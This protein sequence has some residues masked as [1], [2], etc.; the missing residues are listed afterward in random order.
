MKAI[1]RTHL[2]DVPR[3]DAA[4]V[5]GLLG[6]PR[7]YGR[8]TKSVVAIETHI[9]W[10]FLTDRFA[11]KLKKPVRFEFLDFSTPPLRRAAC[12][13]E[14]K[15]N[16]RLAPDV[17]LG[18]EPITLDGD[19]LALNGIGAPVDWVVKM[20]RLPAGRA[21]DRLIVAGEL[22]QQQIEELA[23]KL[24][25]FYVRLPPVN[26][27]TDDYRA[28][29]AQ[30]VDANREELLAPAH[31]LPAEV[32]ER[33]HGAQWLAM[34]L[35][36]D[37]F[38]ERVADGR[39]VEGHGDLR[40]EHVYFA[41]SPIVIDCI[42]FNRDFRQIDVA[43]ELAFLALECEYLGAPQVGEQVIES[44]REASGDRFCSALLE[45]YKTYRA[46]VRAKVLALRAEQ[47]AEDQRASLLSDARRYLELADRHARLLAPPCVT[48]VYGF[49]G[50]GKSTLAAM[51]AESLRMKHLA[52]DSVRREVFS[53]GDVKPAGSE[54]YRPE[55]RMLVYDDM[56]RRA[57][58]ALEA[59]E[60]PVLDGTFPTS[61]LRERVVALAR[62][63]GAA[64]VLLRCHCPEE[65]AVRRIQERQEA[66]ES[67][68]EATPQ[69]LRQQI[70]RQEP[71]SP[72]QPTF[73][74]DTSG[75]PA[76]ALRD[77]LEA[78]REALKLPACDANW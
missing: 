6:S 46:C 10:V 4:A 39:I 45:F 11:Y 58:L 52:T 48:V 55:N 76:T 28:H 30:H 33:V 68:S 5:V 8:Q 31:G 73:E 63:H 62:R 2:D 44:Y 1:S 50:S 61:E 53:D 51:L 74:I 77:A 24:A 57:E 54:V 41:P 36:H 66:G 49:S 60:S 15:L 59:G 42:E 27:T 9:S 29:L 25:Q 13:Q 40:P 26:L 12:E 67:L 3:P 64:P 43:D 22:A 72:G 7:A 69:V 71:D 35:L 75:R 32:V 34:R 47:T 78:I 37:A 38:G 14:V 65:V 21:L 70:E 17:Y 16:R 23:E 19:R 18:V 20:R 56:L